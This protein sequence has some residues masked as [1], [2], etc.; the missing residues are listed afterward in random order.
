[1]HDGVP[2]Y[3]SLAV[4]HFLYQL[5]YRWMVADTFPSVVICIAY[6]LVY[7]LGDVLSFSRLPSTRYLSINAEAMLPSFVKFLINY[8]TDILYLVKNWWNWS[9]VDNFLLLLAS[10]LQTI[11]ERNNCKQRFFRCTILPWRRETLYSK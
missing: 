11:P 8:W 2:A 9:Q 3:Y 7:H 6:L 4:R 10:M 5:P 1:M